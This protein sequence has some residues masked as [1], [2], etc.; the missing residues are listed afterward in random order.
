VEELVEAV[1]WEALGSYCWFHRR[2]PRQPRLT[3]NLGKLQH[4]VTVT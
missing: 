2:I 3:T 1:A 4:C